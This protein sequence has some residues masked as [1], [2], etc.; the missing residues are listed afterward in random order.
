MAKYLM[1][2]ITEVLQALP[3]EFVLILKTND[4]IRSLEYQFHCRAN[5]N[6]YL[7]M[8][9]ICME[10]IVDYRRMKLLAHWR[11]SWY[12]F[13]LEDDLPCGHQSTF[14]DK[15]PVPT[16]ASLAIYNVLVTLKKHLTLAKVTGPVCL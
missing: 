2:D 13:V 14:A 5:F 8:S 10:R 7:K 4:L 6:T 15:F 9:E 16:N 11:K 12:N 1:H 3:T